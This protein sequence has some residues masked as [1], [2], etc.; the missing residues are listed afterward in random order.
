[1]MDCINLY[2]YAYG[3]N[4]MAMDKYKYKLTFELNDFVSQL[5]LNLNC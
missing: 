2:A 1:M 4:A 3:F 5:Y